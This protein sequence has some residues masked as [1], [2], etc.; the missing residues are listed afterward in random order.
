MV[1]WQAG[2]VGIILLGAG[3]SLI[4]RVRKKLSSPQSGRSGCG[5]CSVGKNGVKIKPL[6]ELDSH[7]PPGRY[8]SPELP[9]ASKRP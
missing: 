7:N 6:V 8:R 5:S 4:Q 3:F 1:D 9:E 2:V